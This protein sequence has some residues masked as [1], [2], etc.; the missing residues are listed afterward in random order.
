MERVVFDFSPCFFGFSDFWPRPPLG[1]DT[2]FSSNRFVSKLLRT[3]LDP[4]KPWPMGVPF[5]TICC[6]CLVF[7]AMDLPA[8]DLPVLAVW[9]VGAVCVQD[10]WVH[11]RFG[12]SPDS[13]SAEPPSARPPSA[14]PPKILLFFSVSRLHFHSCLCL[15]GGL[16]VEFW[17]CLKRRDPLMC[18]FRFS[19]C[20]VKPRR[21]LQNVKNIFTV[22]LPLPLLDFRKSQ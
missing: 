8:R 22:D 13:S 15:S 20:R 2:F 4:K 16:P 12:R 5:G 9:C 10:L 17:W 3:I 7:W 18:T 1:P 21:P 19:D 14:G 6:S 11:P